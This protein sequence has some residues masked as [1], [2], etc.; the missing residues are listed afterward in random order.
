MTVLKVHI[1]IVTTSSLNCSS[2]QLLMET[3]KINHCYGYTRTENTVIPDLA[4]F[5]IV[6]T[7]LQPNQAFTEPIL[8]HSLNFLQMRLPLQT[9]DT[10]SQLVSW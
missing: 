5:L 3:N 2:S 6:H 9:S 1:Q 7:R 4:G 8:L 10:A